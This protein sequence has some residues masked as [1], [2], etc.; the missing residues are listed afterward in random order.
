MDPFDLSALRMLWPVCRMT[1]KFSAEASFLVLQR[2]SSKVTSS[3]QWKLSAPQWARVYAR[4]A[5]GSA[6]REVM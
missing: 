2:S 6:S 1:A 3:V 5:F 4:M